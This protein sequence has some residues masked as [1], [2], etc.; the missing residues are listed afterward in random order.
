MSYKDARNAFTHIFDSGMWSYGATRDGDYANVSH[1]ARLRE[2]IIPLLQKYNL[3]SIF[4]ASCGEHCWSREVDWAGNGVNYIGGEIVEAKIASLKEQFPEKDFRVFD[5]IT[6]TFPEVDVWMCKDTMI[7]LPIHYS[8]KAI[9]NF[10]SSNI[11]YCL[12]TVNIF[13]DRATN[14][15]IPEFGPHTTG[16]DCVNCNWVDAPF[17]F[18]E[19]MEIIEYT[20]RD[21][22]FAKSTNEERKVSVNQARFFLFLYHRDQIKDLPFFQEGNEWPAPGV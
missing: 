5:I 21:E 15:D 6:D 12:L 4:D 1:T 14:V 2:E 7:H 9:K 13:G 8:Q 10:L 17:N 11:P 22:E 18:P 20:A 16:G 19:P 3:T